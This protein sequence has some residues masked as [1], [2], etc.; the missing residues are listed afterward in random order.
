VDFLVAHNSS[1]DQ[2]V[3]K[4]CCEKNSLLMPNLPFLCT[5][6]IARKFL[7]IYPTKLSNVCDVLKI[8]LKHHDALS[9][10]RACAKILIHSI[11]KNPNVLTF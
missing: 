11:E 1:F 8:H 7:G 2:G 5:V 3:L 9:D 6:K 4:A 10:A